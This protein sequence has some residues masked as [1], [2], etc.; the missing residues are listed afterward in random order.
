[1]EGAAQWIWLEE[2]AP[3]QWVE[4]YRAFDWDGACARARIAVDSKYTLWVNGELAVVDGGLNRG[5]A[6]GRGY[7]DA[8]YLSPF[9]RPGRNELRAL[10]WYWGNEG[11]N[12]VD[13][14]RGGF[15]FSLPGAD[16]GASWAARLC[17]GYG[18]TRP[19]YPAHL[20][21]GHNV[22]YDARREDDSPPAGWPRARELGPMGCKPF[23][24]LEER[25]VPLMRFGG[26]Q[27][28]AAVRQSGRVYVADLP[29]ACQVQ[30]YFR[31]R[32]EA[33]RRIDVRTDRYTVRGG[34]GDEQNAYNG[35]R[36][37]YVARAGEQEFEAFNW[38]FGEQVRYE[39]EEGVELLEIGYR[40]TGYDARVLGGFRCG[41]ALLDRLMDK[42]AR[43]LLCCMR[44]NFMDCPDRERGQWIG[45][46]S[47]QAPQVFYLLDESGAL[48]LRKSVADFFRLRRGDVLLGNVPGANASELPSQSLCA[49]SQWGMVAQYYAFTGDLDA[50]R[51]AF[52]PTLSYLR[53]W[54]VG[55]EGLLRP[56]K[57]DWRW[58]DH[59]KGVDEPVLE[60][61]WYYSALRFAR[62]MADELGE[63]DQN[64]WLEARLAAIEG[65]FDAAFWRDE[66]Y[67]SG[68]CIDDRAQAMAVLS[69]LAGREK[70]PALIEVLKR[71]AESSPY[72]EA[73]VLLALFE[74]GAG[75]AAL[76]RMRR[77]YR[78]L[79]ENENSTLWEDFSVL[80]T[81]N[82]AWSGGPA[83]AL[84]R[85]AAGLL[86]AGRGCFLVRPV[87]C[88]LTSFAAQ[89]HTPAGPLRVALK[90]GVY[91]V[92]APRALSLR[93]DASLAAGA[94]IEI[95]Y[96]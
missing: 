4:F 34:P 90:D 84:M 28:Y 43:T 95:A 18:E 64:P 35:H 93:A 24:A 79:V 56:R 96:E 30:P 91:A 33:G 73:F 62:F 87:A 66:R 40:E 55:P 53:L 22:G 57:G 14:G 42:C 94:R 46:V 82:H 37:E 11:R 71:V 92:T 65:A 38:F 60:N 29:Y 25:P 89:M 52:R 13:S 50:L 19:P 47:V 5:P 6:P 77:R 49:V 81:R 3:N 78:P 16:S 20:Y 70:Y 15:Y 9:L 26:V 2:S 48:L 67:A 75:E 17:P 74:M 68:D 61:A 54:D 72:M 58:F 85:G 88:G 76:A 8:V 1:M 12:N 51:L 59:G 63:R 39:A 41:D 31:A 80:G 32:A 7:F 27:P 10:V 44:D 69:G 83:T 36:V 23:G 45:D 21:G 86:P